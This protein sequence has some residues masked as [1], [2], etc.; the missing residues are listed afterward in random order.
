MRKPWVE[1]VSLPLRK[2]PCEVVYAFQTAN[3][4]AFLVLSRLASLPRSKRGVFR[5]YRLTKHYGGR[6]VVDNLDLQIPQGCVYGLLGR[7]GAGKSTAL[8]MMTGMVR[9]D[10]RRIELLGEEVD[11]L[12]PKTRAYLSA[13]AK[14]TEV[15]A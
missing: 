6:K 14:G 3:A 2:K 4:T 8:K 5:T 13:A 10:C 1:V 12:S 15:F 11:A 7:N 9:P